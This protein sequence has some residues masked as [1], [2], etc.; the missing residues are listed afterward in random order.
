MTRAGLLESAVKGTFAAAGARVSEDA[1]EI[2]RTFAVRAPDFEGLLATVLDCA[3]RLSKEHA[4]AYQAVQFDLMTVTEARGKF[5]GK[6]ATFSDPLESVHRD[7]LKI[8]RNTEGMWEAT[9]A[10]GR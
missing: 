3:L 2:T 8:E 5:V 1:Q 7:G 10:F 6:P 9:I 4:E